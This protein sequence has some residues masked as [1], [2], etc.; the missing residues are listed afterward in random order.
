M[1]QKKL[2]MLIDA[3]PTRNTLPWDVA[4]GS[5]LAGIAVALVVIATMVWG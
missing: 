2:Q 1:S 3:Q 5:F 4:F